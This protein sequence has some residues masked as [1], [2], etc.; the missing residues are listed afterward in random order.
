MLAGLLEGDDYAAAED[1]LTPV[2]HPLVLITLSFTPECGID[3]WNA[4]R[5][6]N[7]WLESCWNGADGIQTEEALST[8]NT[9]LK[10]LSIT[11][12]SPT[13]VTVWSH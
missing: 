7:S 10:N 4:G 9:R 5:R 13:P 1:D 6:N 8:L 12:P 2:F 11:T 3:Q